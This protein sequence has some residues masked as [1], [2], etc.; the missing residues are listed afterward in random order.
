[1]RL[2]GKQIFILPN[3]SVENPRVFIKHPDNAVEEMA[4]GRQKNR[5]VKAHRRHKLEVTVLPTQDPLH[6]AVKFQGKDIVMTLTKVF[7]PEAIVAFL[8]LHDVPRETISFIHTRA[9]IAIMYLNSLD[10]CRNFL[11]SSCFNGQHG[12]ESSGY[13][14]A[15]TEIN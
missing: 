12:I 15:G 13:R 7:V 9:K 1:M 5:F 14:V 3:G 11:E 6:V 2:E 4:D 10:E 8:S